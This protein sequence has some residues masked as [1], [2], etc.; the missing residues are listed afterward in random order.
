MKVETHA[1]CVKHSCSTIGC[2]GAK[3]KVEELFSQYEYTESRCPGGYADISKQ[4]RYLKGSLHRA[5]DSDYEIILYSH[6]TEYPHRESHLQALIKACNA[7]RYLVSSVLSHCKGNPLLAFLTLAK[8]PYYKITL[9]VL[10]AYLE[11]L[12]KFVLAMTPLE[13]FD[14]FKSSLD[15]YEPGIWFSL[16]LRDCLLSIAVLPHLEP[17]EVVSCTHLYKFLVAFKEFTSNIVQGGVRYNTLTYMMY[18]ND[19][20]SRICQQLKLLDKLLLLSIASALNIPMPPNPDLLDIV[21]A[22][23]GYM[24]RLRLQCFDLCRQ[25]QHTPSVD[26]D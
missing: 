15:E 9:D 18:Y 7:E 16:D 19:H 20:Y 23:R 24:V 12:G 3:M 1:D 21:E 17:L 10:D 2:G 11:Y 22:Y 25:S 14:L 6:C 5:A 13:K 26:S 8:G 4:L